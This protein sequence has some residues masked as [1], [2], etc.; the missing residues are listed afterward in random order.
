M[1]H[2]AS[3]AISRYF[4]KS[5]GKALSYI[6]FG[7]SLGEFLLPIIIVYL[8]SFLYWRDLWI[9]ISILTLVFLPLFSY[10]AAKD[11]KISSR[12]R[13]YVNSKNNF[14]SVKSWTRKEV[15]KDFRF[16]TILPALLS[17]HLL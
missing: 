3:T 17:V 10:F 4:E 12:E 8:L 5:R 16:Y 15:L 9:Q 7:M 1:A 6:W 13:E 11:I 14:Q 2:T